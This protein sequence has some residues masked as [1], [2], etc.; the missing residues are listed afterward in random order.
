MKNDSLA[1]FL[2]DKRVRLKFQT[3]TDIANKA[4][5]DGFQI[6]SEAI[7]LFEIGERIPNQKSR[8]VLKHIYNLNAQE[9]LQLERLCMTHTIQNEVES[10][11]WLVV[12]KS[13]FEDALKALST[14][15]DPHVVDI[16]KL[17]SREINWKK[18]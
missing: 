8:A 11:H 10:D 5:N 17:L 1:K 13:V 14:S 6:T 9:Q 18:T 7:R 15:T 2:A 4:K 3:Y 12:S 16:V